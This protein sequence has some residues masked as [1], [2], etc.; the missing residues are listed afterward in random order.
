MPEF[1]FSVQI[2][3]TFKA[4]ADDEDAAREKIKHQCV[5]D[6]PDPGSGVYEVDLP[7]VS[8]ARED[9]R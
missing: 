5:S 9:E 7:D 2:E 6:L 4:M 3:R 1:K 8:I